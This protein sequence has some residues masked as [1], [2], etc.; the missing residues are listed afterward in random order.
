MSEENAIQSAL[1]SAYYFLK[2]RPRTRVEIERN[3]KKKAQKYGWPDAVIEKALTHLE[4]LNFINDRDFI[5]LFV[6]G[7]NKIKQKSV[8]ALRSELMRLGISKDI[9]DEYFSNNTQNE[10]E[11]AYEALRSR[12]P[13]FARLDKQTRFKK[14]AAFLA[15]RGFSFDTIKKTIAKYD[16]NGYNKG[17]Y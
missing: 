9:L 10:D 11:L 13:R 16:E 4:E 2:F 5:K 6:E 7:R 1:S 15:N 8:F 17:D 3:L 14:V 12:W